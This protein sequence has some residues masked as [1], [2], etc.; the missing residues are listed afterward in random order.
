MRQALLDGISANPANPLPYIQA[1]CPSGECRWP[2]FG[3]LAICSDVFNLTAQGNQTLLAELRKTTATRLDD[4]YRSAQSMF[5]LEIGVE[6]IP[7][8]FPLILGPLPYPT[9]HFNKSVEELLIMDSFIAYSDTK[10]SRPENGTFRDADLSSLRFLELGLF[11][12][13]KTLSSE[14][15][16]GISYTR[17]V[18]SQARARKSVDTKLNYK[19]TM[20]FFTCYVTNTCP[21][22]LGAT[23]LELE[24][25][26][27]APGTGEYVVHLWSALMSSALLFV[28]MFDAGLTD[29]GRGF[30]A[31]N[32]GGASAGLAPSLFGDLL[33][34]ELPTPDEQLLGVRNVSRNI[35]QS[36]SNL[37]GPHAPFFSG[38]HGAQ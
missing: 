27:G 33:A 13:T 17:E 2:D 23:E 7:P 1:V 29:Q 6:L 3:T 5:R 14:V 22:V 11:L 4:L 21:E 20:K 25:P 15:R 28:T 24:P 9:G 36:L 26:P 32:G 16:G 38:S 30:L 12:C 31:S 10:F 37:L 34:T 8:S 19:W 35:A 18:S